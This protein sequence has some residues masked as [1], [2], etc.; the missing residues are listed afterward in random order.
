M[1]SALQKTHGILGASAVRAQHSRLILNLLWTE[2]E[3]SRADLA[4]RTS[5]SRS[6]VSAIV[7]DLLSTNLVKESHAGV[8]S[9][10]RRPILLQ[11]QDDSS[12]II[13]LELGA[14]HVSCVLTDLRC[15]VRA[16]WSAPAPVRDDPEG[17][18]QKMTMAVR[19]VLDAG[20]VPSSRVVGIGVAVPSPVDR[21]RP[22]ELLP[23]ILPKWKGYDIASH[24]EDFLLRPVFVDNDANLGALAELW[25]GAGS[26]AKDLAYIK[27]ATG[28]G[29]GLIIN[30]RIFRG[31]SGIAGEIG[32]TSIDPNGPQCICGL[33]GCLATLIGTPALLKR[34]KDA[35]R[36]SGSNRPAPTSIDELVNAALEGEPTAVELMQYT[37]HQLGIGIANM[38][39]LLNPEMVV[40]G[41]GIAR[42]GDLVLDPVRETIR[43][44]S[45]PASISNTEIR[46]TGLNEWGIAVGAATLVLQGALETPVLFP[47]ESQVAE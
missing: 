32:H 26:S 38:L 33:R 47:V 39:N 4:R 40:L 16:S 30:G 18:L 10:G 45:L 8:S 36:A 21:E 29:A 35:L 23:L 43:G 2:R 12:F 44:L 22:G 25:W 28:I 46:T 6:T 37:G 9:G 19:A 15:S 1:E 41:G 34:A 13:G 11:F 5:L 24:L 7:S 20:G 14:T 3:I 42:A 31:S 27:V 17:A